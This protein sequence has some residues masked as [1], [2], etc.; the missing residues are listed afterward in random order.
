MAI[1][2]SDGE[3]VAAALLAYVRERLPSASLRFAEAP[4]RIGRGFDTYIYAFRLEGEGLDPAWARPLVLRLYPTANQADKAE[5][6]ATVQRFVAEHGY[7]A[8]APLA[9]EREAAGFGLPLMVLERVA[10]VP[11]LD[12]IGA[13]PLG[14]GRLFGAMADAHAALHKLPVDGC[15]LPFDT[16]LV[17]RKL[18]EL[19]PGVERMAD[20]ELSRGL[21]WLD[22]HK[23]VVMD[24][25]RSL[26]HGDFHPLN[27][28]VG[29]DGA[30]T[31]LDWSDAA[32]GDRHSDVA[33]TLVLFRVAWIAAESRVEKLALR[34]GRGFLASRYRMPYER[35][36]PIDATRLRYWQALQSFSGWLLVA[37]LGDP[38][39]PSVAGA[40]E[41]A[42]QRIPAGL[43]DELRRYFWERTR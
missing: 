25:E 31:V 37:E 7:P 8:P 40:R 15:S 17:V 24:E 35:Q 21:R 42:V 28:M 43:D 1:D 41:D 36:L 5:R 26:C 32:I 10:G 11:M 14:I 6:E 23:G 16:P 19:R 3:Q 20:D 30:L 34:Y 33:R 12:R 27:I 4:E 13:N 29:D 39:N 22:E 2:P 9:V 38:T 18:D